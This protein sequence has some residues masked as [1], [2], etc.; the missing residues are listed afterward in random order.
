MSERCCICH[1][2]E[3][4]NQK[5]K[6]SLRQIPLKKHCCREVRAFIE[7]MPP[8]P[9]DGEALIAR[10]HAL[11]DECCRK[12]FF[13]ELYLHC[14]SV[15][16]PDKRYHLDFAFADTDTCDAAV[17]LF[18]DAG[19]AFRTSTR[20]DVPIVYTKHS[21]EI[22][23]FLTYIGASQAALSVMNAK[24]VKDFRS[25]VNRQVNCDTAKIEKQLSSSKRVTDAI[26]LLEKNGAFSR[27]PDTLQA[28]A[29]LRRDNPQLSLAELAAIAG[30]T[31]SGMKHRMEKLVAAAEECMERKTEDGK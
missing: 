21:G 16:D 11:H 22:E 2:M 24:I 4:F 13:R 25:G 3:S 27:L 12:T 14:G 9:N 5:C 28:S 26:A 6:A 17:R 29:I 7:T 30:V 19:F 18:A 15:T 1:K 8:H 23:D 31:K 20:R 10:Y